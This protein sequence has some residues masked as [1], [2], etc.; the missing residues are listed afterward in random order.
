MP[1]MRNESLFLFCAALCDKRVRNVVNQ[2]T[3]VW[4]FKVNHLRQQHVIIIG[5]NGLFY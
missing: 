2:E 1:E 3:V 4:A 5:P